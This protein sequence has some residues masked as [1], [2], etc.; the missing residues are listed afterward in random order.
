MQAQITGERAVHL[1]GWLKPKRGMPPNA[2][3]DAEK[4]DLFQQVD[5]WAGAGM[6]EAGSTPH[7]RKGTASMS[8]TA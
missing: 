7:V 6:A 5:A 3:E 8:S 1:L 4:L 2:G